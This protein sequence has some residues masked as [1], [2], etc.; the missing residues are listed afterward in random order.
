MVIWLLLAFLFVFG[1]TNKNKT[2]LV[3]IV[4]CLGGGKRMES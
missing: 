3:C 1:I 2:H 4:L